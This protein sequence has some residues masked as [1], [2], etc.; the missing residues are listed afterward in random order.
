V[1]GRG[2]DKKKRGV[3][4]IK[5]SFKYALRKMSKINAGGKMLYVVLGLVGAVLSVSVGLIGHI[6]SVDESE[7]VNTSR[8]YIRIFPEKATVLNNV[9]YEEIFAFEDYDFIEKV[10]LFDEFKTFNIE[11]ELYYEIKGSIEIEAHP[12][13]LL[14][15][16]PNKIIYGDYPGDT[17]GIVIDYTIADQLIKDYSH[18]GIETYKDILD[19]SFKLQS[20]GKDFD[21]N[22]ET[23]LN[24]PIVGI[25]NDASPTVWM[26]PELIYSLVMPSLIDPGIFGGGFEF[27]QFQ[28][29]ANYSLG[30]VDITY[31]EFVTSKH[32]VFNIT[33]TY[34]IGRNF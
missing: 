31:S 2:K 33:G 27:K 7:F 24:F 6:S 4:T 14:L 5:D 30:L 21:V 15:L 19:C 23:S 26:K 28:V 17:Y 32:S 8:N 9:S 11:T 22:D 20:S 16:N 13:Q 34:F 25:A 29:K 18:R 10:S 1:E 3:I 12:T